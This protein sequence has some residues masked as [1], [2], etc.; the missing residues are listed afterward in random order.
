MEVH[1]PLGTPKELAA[2]L[3]VSESTL[4]YWRTKGTGPKSVK[5]GKHVRYD[6]S[7]VK[8]WL[9]EQDAEEAD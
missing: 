4:T 2:F 6:W 7:D 3:K 5:F 1:P 9:K 8:R